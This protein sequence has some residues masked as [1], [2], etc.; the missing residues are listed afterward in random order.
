VQCVPQHRTATLQCT[1]VHN[2]ARDHRVRHGLCVA[3]TI[4][5]CVV[6]MHRAAQG[7]KKAQTQ[8]LTGTRRA[9]VSEKVVEVVEVSRYWPGKA[10]KWV[11]G[12]EPETEG[13]FAGHGLQEQHRLSD[14]PSDRRLQRLAE[15]RESGADRRRRSNA[16]VI[17]KSAEVIEE[18]GRRPSRAAVLET[19]DSEEEEVK[20]EKEEEDDDDD[21]AIEARR[22]RLLA[23]RRAQ[24]KAEEEEELAAAGDEEETREAVEQEDESEYEYE[25]ESEEEEGGR[26]LLKPVF[27]ADADRETI[28]E[29]EALEAEQEAMKAKREARL[30]ERQAESRKMLVDIV[31]K[32]E[33]GDEEKPIDFAEIPDDDDDVDELEQFERWKLR[34]L[35]R[36]KKEVEERQQAERERKEIERR[37]NLSEA[38]RRKEDEEFAKQRLDYGKE[39]EKWKFL[40]KYYHKGAYFQEEDET[41]NAKIGPVMMRDYGAPT[42]KDAIGDKAAMPKVMQVKNFGMRSQVKWTH[43]AAEDTSTKDELWAA[44]SGLRSKYQKQ[45]AGMKAAHEFSRPTAKRQKPSGY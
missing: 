18:G 40:Q 33:A 37:R 31:Q 30:Q 23:V 39:K 26:V 14:G 19:A 15:G 35:R 21:E 2:V 38:E 4:G 11:A 41:G 9:G 34:E 45:M 13:G 1:A 5:T 12:D 20:T 10:P 7:E 44:D 17:E 27:V 32:E 42:G 6:P 25:T 24:R 22:E 8:G 43:L 29:R 36:L 16:E 28:K 3:Q